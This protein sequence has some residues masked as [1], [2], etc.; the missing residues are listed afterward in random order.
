MVDA[1]VMVL[2]ANAYSLC[3]CPFLSCPFSIMLDA[4][5]ILI[6]LHTIIS[7]AYNFVM[8]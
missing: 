1:L 8:G 4:N 3:Q 6:S 7:S 2:Y 5:A